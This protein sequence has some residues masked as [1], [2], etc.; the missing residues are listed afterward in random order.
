MTVH[1]W[2]ILC[3]VGLATLAATATAQPAKE[4]NERR[5]E[6]SFELSGVT[7]NPFDDA[8][9]AVRV[10]LRLPNGKTV[11]VPA[12]FDGG[13]SWRV[14]WM[15][16]LPGKYVWSEI[17]R[18]G[19]TVAPTNYTGREATVKNVDRRGFIRSKEGVFRFEDGSLYYPLGHNVAW[20]NGAENTVA[21]ATSRFEKMGKAG[22]N[23]SRVWMS[24]WD[25]KNLD[26]KVRP[27]EIDLEAARRWDNI[28]AAAER[29][30]IYFQTGVAASRPVLLQ[31]R[32]Q[33]GR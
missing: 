12:F 8:E 32:L 15:P 19:K 13:T 20:G 23:W 31:H 7:G 30:G 28:V 22:E 9:N 14:R 21:D 3:A 17:T 18:N 24:H 2:K 11:A 33:L 25:G 27:G 10:Q 6:A 1:F 26:W 5:M 4:G 16:T 29:N